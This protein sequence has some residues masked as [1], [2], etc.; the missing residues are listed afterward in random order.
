[1]VKE[2]DKIVNARTGQVMIFK[3]TG[4][5]TNGGQLEIECFNPPSDER[6][7]IHIHPFQES[8]NEVISGRLHFWVN[9]TEQV[10]GPGE[11]IVIPAGVPHRFWNE[12][13][14]PAHHIG[15]FS[16]GLN[17][18]SFFETFFALSRDGKLNKNGIP[19]FLHVSVIALAFKDEIR[20]STPPWIIQYLTYLLLAPIGRL[21]GYRATYTSKN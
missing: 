16:P 19:N 5:G 10:I 6:E 17:I 3:R 14:E 9:G 7:P 4:S 11:Q 2:G 13:D 12:D 8:S 1:M 18:A 20:L 21:V 15:R